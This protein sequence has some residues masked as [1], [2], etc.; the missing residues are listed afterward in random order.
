[1]LA[2]SID[3]PKAK[4]CIDG[5]DG[6]SEV[7]ARAVVDSLLDKVAGRT[8]AQLR[9]MLARRVAKADPEAAQRRQERSVERR[10]LGL[11]RDGDGTATLSGRGL[12]A[13][14]AEEA[15]GRVHAIAA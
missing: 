8:T 14:R 7:R 15:F 3:Y 2:G 4:L 13:H 1:M 9:P 12:P 5:T 11:Y 10:D 6:L